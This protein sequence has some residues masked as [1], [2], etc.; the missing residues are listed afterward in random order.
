MFGFVKTKTHVE[1]REALP[2]KAGVNT[3]RKVNVVI[4]V[5]DTVSHM[6]F[7]RVM[8]R[9]HEYLTKELNSVGMDG[10]TKVGDNTFPNISKYAFD[11]F[12]YK[13][14]KNRAAESKSW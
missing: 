7:I 12:P 3:K 13:E 4:L 2:K 5:L 14:H 10:Y 1:T 11:K 8:P 9:T 6:N